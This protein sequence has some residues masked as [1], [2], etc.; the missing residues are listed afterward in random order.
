MAS[1]GEHQ[2]DAV[3]EWLASRCAVVEV[4]SHREAIRQLFDVLSHSCVIEEQ[5]AAAGVCKFSG[6]A[7]E[8]ALWLRGRAVRNDSMADH[9]MTLLHAMHTAGDNAESQAAKSVLSSV[10][11]SR[12]SARWLAIQILTHSHD[13]PISR[14]ARAVLEIMFKP[15]IDADGEAR[16]GTSE[17][18]NAAARAVIWMVRHSL[19]AAPSV[20]RARGMVD[21]PDRSALDWATQLFDQWV[22]SL[23]CR[24]DWNFRINWAAKSGVAFA[25]EAVNFAWTRVGHYVESE[26][27]P[28]A[29][30]NRIL[31][32]LW[33]DNWRQWKRLLKKQPHALAE[34]L[35]DVLSEKHRSYLDERP[36]LRLPNEL[37]DTDMKVLKEWDAIDGLL[38]GC[39][40]GLS[41][42]IPTE[43]WTD[44]RRKL[45]VDRS[46]LERLLERC[47][48]FNRREGL[49]SITGI[50]P[51][52]IDQRWR[53]LRPKL[54]R[55][56]CI[57]QL[58][59]D[60]VSPPD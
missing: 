23:L 56:D 35:L 31:L 59:M 55:L 12:A 38:A 9:A 6:D 14:N 26:G 41:A 45:N 50:K 18:S 1:N 34:E 20:R 37:S 4:K 43:L 48:P 58:L 60:F 17:E 49:A 16:R 47:E 32:N 25:D 28:A 21:T 19:L 44:W 30:L 13:N 11:N 54:A 15:A 46:A 29:W 10:G 27:S 51:G 7:R 3:A 42:I 57:S 40:A 2:F 33:R 8:V 24:L 53:R 36:K 39:E 22:R 5:A 52:T